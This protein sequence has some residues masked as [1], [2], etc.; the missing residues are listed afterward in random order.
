[1]TVRFVVF[2]EILLIR[3]KTTCEKSQGTEYFRRCGHM[4]TE[5]TCPSTV[6]CWRL[7]N[8][9]YCDLF[10]DSCFL[11]S[12]FRRVLNVVCFI[13]GNSP[14][15]EFYMPTFRNTLFHL[16]R[17]I[18]ILYTY[19]P[20]K[21]EQ[22]VPKRRRIKFRRQGITRKRHITCPLLFGK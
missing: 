22:G 14:A 18:G 3:R 17:R 9:V 6:G 7:Y 21:M 20:M 2:C 12:N 5:Q 16:H 13:L 8:E 11:I 1:M 15:S 19:P 4:S 10:N